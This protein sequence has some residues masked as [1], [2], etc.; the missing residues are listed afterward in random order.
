MKTALATLTA[1][2]L[3]AGI[4][5]AG[6]IPEPDRQ[7]HHPDRNRPATEIAHPFDAGSQPRRHTAGLDWVPARR[8]R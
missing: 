3:L 1:T 8:F 6:A 7:W 5:P 2:I 4:A